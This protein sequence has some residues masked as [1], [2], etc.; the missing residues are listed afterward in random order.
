MKKLLTLLAIAACFTSTQAQ[1]RSCNLE[2]TLLSPIEYD[3]VQTGKPTDFSVSVK[4]LGPDPINPADTILYTIRYDGD[5]VYSA[6][7]PLQKAFKGYS[8]AVEQEVTQMIYAGLLQNYNT[9]GVHKYCIDAK[10]MNRNFTSGTSDPI[11]TNNTGCHNVYVTIFNNGINDINAT[12]AKLSASPVPSNKSINLTYAVAENANV[13]LFVTDMQGRTI[14]EVSDE[15]M[16]VG[17]YNKDIDVST[18]APGVYF[19]H[20]SI[21]GRDYTTKIVRN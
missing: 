18:L 11:I 5:S 12:Q 3:F 21:N 19:A 17:S 4:N 7:K 16:T 9:G 10:L 20:L 15:F 2:I 14:L 8:I 1:V 13:K 6:G